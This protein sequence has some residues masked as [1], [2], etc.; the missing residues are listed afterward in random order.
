MATW[1]ETMRKEVVFFSLVITSVGL[2]GY[3]L[4]FAAHWVEQKRYKMEMVQFVR[5]NLEKWNPAETTLKT[6][7]RV[8]ALQG[9]NEDPEFKE[10]Q[11]SEKMAR[12]NHYFNENL[13]D[14]EFFQLPP[15]EQTRIKNNFFRAN[16]PDLA[17]GIIK[18]FKEAF[19]QYSDWSNEDLK[20]RLPELNYEGVPFPPS[21]VSRERLFFPTYIALFS[22]V[23]VLSIRKL[24]TLRTK[25]RSV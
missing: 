10:L 20:R 4:V 18:M 8:E 23:L 15:E 13:A 11:D 21:G 7:P 24:K 5:G 1:Q 25:R 12:Y 14:R 17:S 6:Y 9:W 3:V 22:Y 2:V 19:P 16:I